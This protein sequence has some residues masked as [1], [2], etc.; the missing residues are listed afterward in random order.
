MRKVTVTVWFL[1]ILAGVCSAQNQAS[2]PK[3][4]PAVCKADL[5]AWSAQKIETLTIAQIMEQMN[6]MY[7]CVEQ[8]KKHEKKMHAYLDEFYRTHSELADRTFDFITRH[9]LQKQFGEEENGSAPD[10]NSEPK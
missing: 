2:E 1:L 6:E 7:A 5:K 8:Q 3:P 10:A 4:S 9:D